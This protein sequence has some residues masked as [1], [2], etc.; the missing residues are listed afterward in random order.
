MARTRALCLALFVSAI[1]A[2]CGGGSGGSGNNGGS[3]GGSGSGGGGTT[4]TNPCTTALL[5][6]TT[7]IAGVGLVAGGAA[8]A[9]DKDKKTL[10]DGSPRG[11][12]WEAKAL[13]EDALQKRDAARLRSTVA[14]MEADRQNALTSPSP[15]AED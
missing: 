4:T 12:L 15:V 2:A 5:A 8:P 10:V 14:Q 7:E 9:L 13:H 11:R 3:S 6:D 1:V